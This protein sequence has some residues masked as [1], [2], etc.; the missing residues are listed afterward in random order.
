MGKKIYIGNLSFGVDDQA[1]SDVFARYG[2]VE[3]AR[4]IMDRDS[5]RSKGFAFVEMTNSD[6]AANAIQE[7]NG[8]ELSGREMKVSEAKPMEPRSN[9]RDGNRGFNSFRP[10]Y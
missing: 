6:D 7:L 2:S 8:S 3:S 9:N 10:R 4:V 5:G 1:L